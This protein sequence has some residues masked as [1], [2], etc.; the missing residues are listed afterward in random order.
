M[1][2]RCCQKPP[3]RSERSKGQIFLGMHHPH[4]L[5]AGRSV[6]QAPKAAGADPEKASE[7]SDTVRDFFCLV[8]A[9][10]TDPFTQLLNPA[11]LLP[12]CLKL[13]A[14]LDL[15]LP[16]ALGNSRTTEQKSK[17]PR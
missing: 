9:A 6:T 4:K 11:P 10:G 15:A 7:M 5:V 17:E 14:V 8:G 3:G 2:W 16:A 12:R 13:F 1:T